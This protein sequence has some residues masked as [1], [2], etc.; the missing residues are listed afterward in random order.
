MLR[1]H[2][3]T[4]FSRSLLYEQKNKI[5]IPINEYTDILP[6][7]NSKI[8][9]NKYRNIN[10]IHNIIRSSTLKSYKNVYFY[11]SML[12]VVENRASD[13]NL[14]QLNVVLKSL[15]KAKIYKYSLL[16]TVDILILNYL[17]YLNN[18]I[19]D[20]KTEIPQYN[21][22]NLNC[23]KNNYTY[24]CDKNLIN[25]PNK[26]C[27]ELRLNK[28]NYKT[29]VIKEKNFHL[30]IICDQINI[31]FNIFK[32]YKH[33]VQFGFNYVFEK[34]FFFL[35]TNYIYLKNKNIILDLWLIYL[36]IIIHKD[37]I[38]NIEKNNESILNGIT[39]PI[40]TKPT[41]FYNSSR[42][43][44]NNN[45][46]LQKYPSQINKLYNKQKKIKYKQ[47]YN[48]HI[49]YIYYYTL[50]FKNKPNKKR[51]QNNTTFCYDKIFCKNNI[52]SLCKY[53]IIMILKNKNWTCF[54]KK[55]KKKI[56]YMNNKN[57]YISNGYM[58]KIKNA[59][60]YYCIYSQIKY[61]I[62]SNYINNHM[63][64]K[65]EYFPKQFINNIDFIQQIYEL[66]YK[67]NI[68]SSAFNKYVLTQHIYNK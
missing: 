48:I 65:Q 51:I 61:L 43:N 27:K 25:N 42:H 36:K 24:D 33:F 53:V 54:H 20:S 57:A 5:N 58:Y 1:L 15:I 40:I 11:K 56:I 28:K 62:K 45:S 44:I 23:L 3:I 6:N 37:F 32:S 21:I 68:I 41:V 17:N 8:Y 10:N 13:L 31:L 12:K 46:L 29:E 60:I 64:L 39:A 38:T 26:I 50:V 16:H 66:M 55:K 47:K 14:H 35:T 19:K 2:N 9:K 18:L 22:P 34:L 59:N 30:Y 49:K 7:N 52:Y 63:F 4:R 67:F